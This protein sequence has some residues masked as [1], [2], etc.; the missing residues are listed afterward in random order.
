MGYT[1][2]AEDDKWGIG[3]FACDYI[4][5][6]KMS[7]DFK[8]PGTLGIIQAY[9]VWERNKKMDYYPELNTKQ[10]LD[11]A[12][13][14]PRL[15]FIYATFSDMSVDLLSKLKNDSTAVL[16]IDTSNDHGMAEQR[17]LFMDLMDGNCQVPV[18]IGRY[19]GSLTSEILQLYASTDIG[20]LLIDGLGEGIFIA[21]EDC[22]PI[23][24]VNQTA[25]GILQ[26]SRT[27]ISKTEY[28][29]CPSCGRTLI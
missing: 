6:N 18:I 15:N 10:Y 11:N 19:Y 25:F 13:L 24:K 4:H 28:I 27:R 14:H 1:Y 17:R 23:E 29:S 9:S 5:I 21:A 2:F 22:G 26:A 16:L 8:I 3:D 20:A 7:I 12:F